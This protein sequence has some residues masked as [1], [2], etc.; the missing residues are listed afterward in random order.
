LLSELRSR[1]EW[2][3]V[4]RETDNRLIRPAK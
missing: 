4:E 3:F 1:P 2:N